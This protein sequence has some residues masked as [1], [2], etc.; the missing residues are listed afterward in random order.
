MKKEPATHPAAS[1]L[2]ELLD[3]PA[4]SGREERMGRLITRKVQELGYSCETDPAGNL[5][6]RIGGRDPKAPLV[7]MAAHM[8]EIG[9]VV[10]HIE[11]DGRLLVAPSGGLMPHKIGECI[12]DI[13]GDGNPVPGVLTVGLSG[14]TYDVKRSLTWDDCY[15]TTGLSP[16]EL[17]EAGIRVGSTAVP[18]R[19]R[20][21]P[22]IF[23]T[24]SDPLLAA[25]LF[26]DRMG[27]VTLLRLLEA[28]RREKITPAFPLIA[29]FTVQEEG[30]CY[31]AKVL[32]NRERP[33]VFIA[34]DGCPVTPEAPLVLDGRPGV[35]TKDAK[36]HYDQSLVRDLLRMAHKAGTELQPAVYKTAYGDAS[37]VFDAG[38]APRVA[39]VG[40]VRENS[41]GFEISRLSV[42]D[43]LLKTLLV[44][45]RSWNSA[46]Q[47]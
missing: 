39:L 14:H 12:L 6:V 46:P 19:G 40:H 2:A 33:E 26:D 17:A 13:I 11:P 45:V 35:W 38:G 44:F 7:V 36:A 37:A 28:M 3:V 41:H 5:L 27:C 23:G 8:D 10:T 22:L 1:L 31:G 47:S 25:W 20:R 9:M 16:A 42:F 29:A 15:V 24:K 21:G 32:A 18:T 34:L 43:N 4:P 30:G